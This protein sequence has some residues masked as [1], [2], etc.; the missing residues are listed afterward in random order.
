MAPW[1]GKGMTTRE[2]RILVVQRDPE[3]S[4]RIEEELDGADMRV[5]GP[6][7]DLQHAM[8]RADG[9]MVAAVLLGLSLAD[10]SG[11]ETFVRFHGR[12]PAL[13][14]IVTAPRADESD[15]RRAVVRGARLYLLDEELGRGLLAPV[16]S[17]VARSTEPPGSAGAHEEH[18]TSATVPRRLLHDLGNFLAVAT[19]EAELLVEK[20]T[21][22]HPLAESLR[23]LNAALAASVRL[24]RQFAASWRVG[25]GPGE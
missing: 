15:A 14:V 11:L 23:D 3:V 20:A 6:V 19:G 13:P 25:P 2:L 4:R 16:L 1:K 22:D 17:H 8:A 7:A 12:H 9:E 10:S 21:D 24:F 18:G 5:A